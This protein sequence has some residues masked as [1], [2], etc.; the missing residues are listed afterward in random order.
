M[1]ELLMKVVMWAGCQLG[2]QTHRHFRENTCTPILLPLSIRG[3]NSAP[4]VAGTSVPV[5]PSEHKA[6]CQQP[7]TPWF[8]T[9]CRSALGWGIGTG[10]QGQGFW[11]VSNAPQ[12]LQGP[13]GKAL[14]LSRVCSRAPLYSCPAT[15]YFCFLFS[16]C[17][18]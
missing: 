18:L 10:G 4:G 14:P 5:S 3:S 16:G 12:I 15:V 6:S 2:S 7:H 8:V 9:S 1:E 13:P 11:P 17:W